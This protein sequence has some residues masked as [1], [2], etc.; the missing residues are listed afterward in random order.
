MP[1][2][3]LR[4][5]GPLTEKAARAAYA[6]LRDVNRFQDAGGE[7]G[8]TTQA[9]LLHAVKRLEKAL[10]ADEA[11]SAGNAD[12]EGQTEALARK[13]SAAAARAAWSLEN[14]RKRA[15]EATIE[16]RAL[17]AEDQA[18]VKKRIAK[19]AKREWKVAKNTVAG[20]GTP[21]PAALVAKEAAKKAKETA[22]AAQRE[23]EAQRRR[24]DI[25]RARVAANVSVERRGIGFGGVVV[26]I[27][28]ALLFVFVVLPLGGLAACGAILADLVNG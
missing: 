22:K 21:D 17:E 18:L 3:A 19:A 9:L 6:V 7:L 11:V 27:V 24:A 26:A 10:D 12:M 15:P 16:E 13:A 20:S 14:D 4:A 1:E 2:E 5:L 28:I 8:L 25:Q 23:A